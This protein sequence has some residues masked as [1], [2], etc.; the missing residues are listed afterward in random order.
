M[1]GNI[2]P[3][4]FAGEDILIT[5]PI[6]DANLSGQATDED[7][8]IISYLWV[9]VSG[10]NAATIV[11]PNSNS[12]IVENLIEGIYAFEL[13]VGDNG[14]LSAS[15]VV[16]VT[17]AELDLNN[18]TFPKIFSPNG[19]GN[20]DFWTWENPERFE[21]CKLIIFTSG[22][23]K[24]YEKTSYDNTWDGSLSGKPLN[25]G[26]YYFTLK[27]NDGKQTSGGVRIIR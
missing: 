3:T 2:A 12:T 15:D 1:A 26:G 24:V 5:L 13:T 27:C 4:V 22:G 9:Q 19:D 20:N 7:G 6:S 17:V 23:H 21:G 16:Q 8:E 25:E 10:P 14:G 18:V 11:Q